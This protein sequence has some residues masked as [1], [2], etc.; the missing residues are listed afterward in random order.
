MVGSSP[1]LWPG[2]VAG[3]LA[4]PVRAVDR[5]LELRA[6]PASPNIDSDI[7]FQ[8]PHRR[9]PAQESLLRLQRLQAT[10]ICD[11]LWLR[12]LA[13]LLHRQSCTPSLLSRSLEQNW[14]CRYQICSIISLS[15]FGHCPAV[16]SQHSS[17]KLH[18]LSRAVGN[19]V[20]ASRAS[21][22][23]NGL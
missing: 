14:Q 3:D 7:T 6:A 11:V 5:R 10:Y 9:F 2:V 12:L 19:W 16:H 18:C 1:A 8:G 21:I 13:M 20:L 15:L 23:Y 17:L 4:L 22:A